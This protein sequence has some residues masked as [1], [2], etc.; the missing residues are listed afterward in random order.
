MKSLYDLLVWRSLTQ[1]NFPLE[2]GATRFRT[3]GSAPNDSLPF[4]QPCFLTLEFLNSVSN[5]ELSPLN[6]KSRRA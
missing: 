1:C 6:Y 5:L 4:R 2:G 3:L